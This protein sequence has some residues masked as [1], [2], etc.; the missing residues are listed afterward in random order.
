MLWKYTNHASWISEM[1][2]ANLMAKTLKRN[3]FGWDC[4]FLKCIASMAAALTNHSFL[5]ISPHAHVLSYYR[6]CTRNV[7]NLKALIFHK[8][9]WK[10][11]GILS[12]L[13][14]GRLKQFLHLSFSLRP[15]NG[16]IHIICKN[17][18]NGA[19]P[20]R[21]KLSIRSTKMESVKRVRTVFG[22]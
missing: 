7:G 11:L 16:I 20:L 18:V 1:L 22:I 5:R 8:G 6:K 4:S 21:E 13:P 19:V 17:D 9:R 15:G 3:Q 12:F 14:H 2:F 10:T